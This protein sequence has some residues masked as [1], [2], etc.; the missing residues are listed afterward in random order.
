VIDQSISHYRVIEKLGGGGMGVVYKAE[1]LKLGRFVAL[2]FLPDDVAH[3]PQALA[4]FEREARAASALNHP[5][6]CTV[7]EIDE[8]ASRAFIAMEFLE[9]VT[10]K[11]RIAGRAIEL[12]TLLPLAIEIADALEAA[13]SAGIVHRDIKPANIFL[14]N[15]GHAKI[16]DFGLAKVTRASSS[17]SQLAAADTLTISHEDPHL[18]SPGAAVG[19]IAYMSPE[20]ARAKELDAR[21]DLF[22]FGAVLYEMATGKQPFRGDSTATIYDGILNREPQTPEELNSELPAK[23][24]D[25]IR[26]ALEKDR[27]LRYRTAA[28]MRTDLQRLKRDSE[29]GRAPSASS[30]ISARPAP[31]NNRKLLAA[32]GIGIAALALAVI[33]LLRQRAPATPTVISERQLTHFGLDEFATKAVISPN[34][35][36]IL[37]A[38]SAGHVRISNIESGEEHDLNLPESIRA[39][40]LHLGWFPD[41]E[42]FLLVARSSGNDAAAEAWICSILGGEPQKIRDHVY[43]IHISPDGSSM[44][45]VTRSDRADLWTMDANGEHAQ[46]IFHASAEINLLQWSPTGKRLAYASI[47][48]NGMGMSV[49]SVNRDGSNPVPAFDDPVMDYQPAGM[50][51][52]SDGR[53]LF[54]R[55]TSG[56]DYNVWEVHLDPDT[57]VRS[58][59]PH[60]ITHMAGVVLGFGNV[61]TDGRYLV[62]TKGRI[63]G[64]VYAADIRD[65]GAG[66]EN[67]RRIT[68]SGGYDYT[69]GWTADSKDVLFSSDRLGR[70]QIYRQPLAEEKPQL[71]SP[72]AKDEQQAAVTPDGQ[73]LLYAASPQNKGNTSQS[74]QTI[75]RAPVAGGAGQPLFE[76]SPGE[77]NLDLHCP[78]RSGHPCVIGRM[79]NQDLVFYELDPMKGQGSE[80]GRTSV[81]KPGPFMS[82]NLSHDGTQIAVSGSD[83]LEK[84][85]RIINLHDH[86]EHDLPLPLFA[87]GLC[88]SADGRGLYITGQTNQ[89]FLIWQDLAGNS[90]TLATRGVPWFIAPSASPDGHSLVYSQQFNEANAFLLEHF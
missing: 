19:T 4:R 21:T 76:I 66:L 61:S 20:Q 24:G 18:T 60:P 6:I 64:N 35:R 89:W 11:H 1:D 32:A 69:V 87:E 16:L 49:G 71:L 81:G 22:S 86:T 42:K 68:T 62:I 83:K 38:T 23:L 17:A 26:K 50:G 67:P 45:F 40:V 73:W 70:L 13:H 46:K 52:T 30:A 90:K 54:I 7:Y 31:S 58:G 29:S 41:G 84:N 28:D 79:Q 53:F 9:G 44:A 14:T 2:K 5:N 43:P 3:D 80:L 75:L 57:G 72:G 33:W 65:G 55:P 27:D 37:Y 34:G 56:T 85:V 8:Q 25:I 15:R 74:D 88:W 82:W 77:V 48:A 39:H 12:E 59:E 10:L 36:Y 47:H 63:F 78:T 51:W